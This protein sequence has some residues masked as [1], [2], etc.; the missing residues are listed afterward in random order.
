ME[1][2]QSL[3][4]FM[5]S[6]VPVTET[7]CW[8]WVGSVQENSGLVA[9][10]EAVVPDRFSWEIHFGRIPNGMTVCHKCMVQCCVNPSHLY[11][12]PG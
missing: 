7:G 3:D 8:M 4:R 9:D 12:A 2:Q 6:V 10:N 1:S 5:E 11:L